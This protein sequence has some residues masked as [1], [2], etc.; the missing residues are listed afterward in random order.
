MTALWNWAA[1]ELGFASFKTQSIMPFCVR[2]TSAA[3][4]DSTPSLPPQLFSQAADLLLFQTLKLNLCALL[5]PLCKS[6]RRR[7]L[8]RLSSIS[9]SFCAVVRA[10]GNSHSA[11]PRPSTIFQIVARRSNVYKAFYAAVAA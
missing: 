7:C 2:D 6:P 10:M 8:R 5:L 1:C 11:P 4:G 9:I 3:L